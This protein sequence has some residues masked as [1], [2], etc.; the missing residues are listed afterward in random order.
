MA[1]TQRHEVNN[2][3]YV[4]FGG[5]MRSRVHAYHLPPRLPVVVD[6]AVYV[7]GFVTSANIIFIF[8]TGIAKFS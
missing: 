4:D 5:S 6:T 7:P 3:M 1:I 2:G 8:Q